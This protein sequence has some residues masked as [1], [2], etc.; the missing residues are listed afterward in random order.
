MQFL[1]QLSLV[2]AAAG[3]LLAQVGANHSL[4]DKVSAELKA[5]PNNNPELTNDLV[6]AA[7]AEAVNWTPDDRSLYDNLH[8]RCVAQF[9]ITLDCLNE[10]ANLDVK[11][12]RETLISLYEA[13]KSKCLFEDFGL[14]MV[15]YRAAWLLSEMFRNASSERPDEEYQLAIAVAQSE[16]SAYAQELKNLLT[17]TKSDAENKPNYMKYAN[18]F[19]YEPIRAL[20]KLVFQAL[21]EGK[22]LSSIKVAF[23]ARMHLV[24]PAW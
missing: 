23:T 2:L 22:S 12:Y 24:N 7:V 16:M 13:S 9:L 3:F 17:T 20:R 6:K 15:R 21:E 10:Y 18:Y 1:A 5:L 19:A 11:D 8:G 4:V 14:I